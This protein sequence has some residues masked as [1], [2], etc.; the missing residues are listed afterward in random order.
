MNPDIPAN[1]KLLH[2]TL[3]VM[4][5]PLYAVVLFAP[6]TGILP[7][8]ARCWHQGTPLGAPLLY[9]FL[10]SCFASMAW[11]LRRGALVGPITVL[12]L[13]L[14]VSGMVGNYSGTTKTSALT[15]GAGRPMLGI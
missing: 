4:L 1:R 9:V 14:V 5:A 2:M 8:L 12:L 3:L 11:L 10:L 13:T 6:Y 7:N 15:I